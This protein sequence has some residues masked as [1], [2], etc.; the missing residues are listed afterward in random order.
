MR[1]P[2]EARSLG[3]PSG[4]GPTRVKTGR[5]GGPIRGARGAGT[6]VPKMDI[7]EL[8]DQELT[9]SAR[10]WRNRAL[11]GEKDA[12]GMAHALEQELRRRSGPHPI[13]DNLESLDTRP[14]AQR[15]QPPRRSWKFW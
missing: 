11:R 1:F 8:Q 4:G 15:Q 5:D 3:A 9:A 14:Q 2:T 10:E 12:R 6:I 7:S 13:N